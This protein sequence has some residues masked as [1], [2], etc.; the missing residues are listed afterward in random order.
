MSMYCTNDKK[1]NRLN[2]MYV[3]NKQINKYYNN[4]FKQKHIL[5]AFLYCIIN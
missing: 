3:W 2:Q 5:N 1:D 4:F